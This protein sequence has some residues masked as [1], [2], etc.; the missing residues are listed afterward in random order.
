MGTAAGPIDRPTGA[1]HE[2]VPYASPGDLA[3]GVAPRI[4]AAVG[5]G[6]AVTA[7]LDDET[8]AR[9][10]AVLGAD[11]DAVDFRDPLAVHAV[12]G[13]TTAKRWA[14]AGRDVT[15]PGARALIVGQ[16]ITGLPGLDAGY[17]SRLCIG[18]E[19]AMVGLPLTV[20]C[21]YPDAA[22]HHSRVRETHP[23]LTS[24]AGPNPHYRAPQ[25]AVADH[26]GPPPPDLGRP[27][28]ELEFRA[29]DLGALRHRV[30][31]VATAAGLGAERVSDAVLVV[32][33]L[34]SNSVEH[35]PGRGRLRF[36]TGTGLLVEVADTGRLTAP[37]P[38]LA[39][40][41]PTGRRGRGLWLASELSDVLQV[42]A[43]DTGTVIRA[44]WPG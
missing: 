40:P 38:G 1:W 13:F 44:G 34:A 22:E 3:A 2:A 25:D 26:P 11:A 8:G 27:M 24:V 36:W 37:F 21:V 7:V 12:P 14:R 19:V 15:V 42:W 10:R 23:V 5:A 43:D 6:D 41:P 32:N 33:E 31:E 17:W 29:A 28:G 20:L 16:Q 4:G 9:L 30:T 35:G 39:L 18:L